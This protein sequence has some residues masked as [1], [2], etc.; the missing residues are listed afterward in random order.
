MNFK[1]LKQTFIAI[2]LCGTFQAQINAKINAEISVTESMDPEQI[3]ESFQKTYPEFENAGRELR[4][5]QRKFE[6]VTKACE[7]LGYEMGLQEIR[8]GKVVHLLA[9]QQARIREQLFGEKLNA[10]KPNGKECFIKTFPTVNP[11][12]NEAFMRYFLF[13][14]K[15][16]TEFTPFPLMYGNNPAATLPNPF[17][18]TTL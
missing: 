2:L 16:A 8:E 4:I 9:Y 3:L 5:S 13:G 18:T 7:K 11:E 14:Y 1:Y 15:R 17:I 10:K 12:E 6:E